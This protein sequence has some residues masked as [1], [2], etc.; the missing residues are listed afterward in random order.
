MMVLGPK[1]VGAFNVSMYKFYICAVFGIIIEKLN[2]MHSVTT[3][4]EIFT[5]FNLKVRF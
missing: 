2:N 4:K 3:K 1:H 5:K